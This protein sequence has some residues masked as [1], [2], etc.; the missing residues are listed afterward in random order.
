MEQEATDQPFQ[1]S[2]VVPALDEADRIEST[3]R[4][5]R[6]YVEK[7]GIAC[8]LIV[9]DDGSADD[10]AGVVRGFDPGPLSVRLLRNER[11]RGKGC[12]V[13]QGVL[14]A[15]GRIIL[16][17]DADLSTPIEE[18]LKL[19][20]W[21]ERGYAVVIG[22]RDLPGSR[23][24]PPQPRTR[25]WL[26]WVFRALRR[27]ILLPNLRDTQCGFKC[28][29]ASAAREIFS[30][31]TIDGWLFDCEI[32]GIA[33]RLGYRIREV[34]VIWRNHPD[35]RVD[36]VRELFTAFPTLLAIR[37]RIKSIQINDMR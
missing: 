18:F 5:I 9:V 13:R 27:Q 11:N 35:S 34:G 17:S 32:L 16:M 28:F 24:D 36:V 23:L 2:I 3:L 12:S 33:E 6:T 15:R 37:R 31:G 29:E 4:T 19:K 8:E 26:A 10:T 20:T 22:S 7:T 21:L 30:R 1:L 25:R 14:A